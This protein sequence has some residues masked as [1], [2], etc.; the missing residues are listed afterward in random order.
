MLLTM[1]AAAS[2]MLGRAPADTSGYAVGPN[3][4]DRLN[5]SSLMTLV[6][7][8]MCLSS[9]QPHDFRSSSGLLSGLKRLRRSMG[10]ER[11]TLTGLV[12]IGDI[13]APC[14]SWASHS[15]A[16]VC[17]VRRGFHPRAM[18]STSKG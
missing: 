18:R 13:S 1:A 8:S 6:F 4:L 17:T 14:D 2:S 16:G 10:E 12:G 9:S 11:T 5:G 7:R 3:D 15:R